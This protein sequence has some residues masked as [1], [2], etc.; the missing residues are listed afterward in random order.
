MVDWPQ[1]AREIFGTWVTAGAVQ[2]V[3]HINNLR[4]TAAWLHEKESDPRRHHIEPIYH[5]FLYSHPHGIGLIQCIF[6][7]DISPD[8][9]ACPAVFSAVVPCPSV[10]LFAQH[11]GDI[12]MFTQLHYWDSPPILRQEAGLYCPFFCES[13]IWCSKWLFTKASTKIIF[14]LL[15]YVI[16]IVIHVAIHVV[17]YC[18]ITDKP[19][20][21]CC[22][23]TNVHQFEMFFS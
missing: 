7:Y 2:T 11:C 4:M 19:E 14:C 21:A 8:S 17:K 3:A 15:V 1:P 22:M 5:D 10:C 16:L 18:P 13:M 9:S 12:C 6:E 23:L 20:L